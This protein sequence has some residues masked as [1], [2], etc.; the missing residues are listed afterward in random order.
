MWVSV[1]NGVERGSGLGRN[2][3]QAKEIAAYQAYQYMQSIGWT[4]E[5]HTPLIIPVSL[6][7]NKYKSQNQPPRKS[8]P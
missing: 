8:H 4:C 1:V 5:F 7:A 6:T 2:Q 3:K